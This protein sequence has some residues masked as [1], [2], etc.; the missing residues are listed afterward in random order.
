[1][2]Q[3]LV[4][5]VKRNI[6]DDESLC[7]LYYHWSAYPYDTLFE[8]DTFSK[9]LLKELNCTQE[10]LNKFSD[11]EI[12]LASIRVVESLGGGIEGG[13]NSP[14]FKFIS[15][16][17]PN[18]EFKK[19]GINRTYGLISISEDGRENLHEWMEGHAEIGIDDCL[20]TTDVWY[21]QDSLEEFNKWEEENYK[22][23]DFKI[24][25]FSLSDSISINDA[26]NIADTCKNHLIKTS[27]G[28][29]VEPF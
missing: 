21:G 7:T 4:V 8:I 5:D 10:N 2:G 26:M 22:E 24:V 29:Y 14:E 25:D 17:F 6:G 16:K 1:M 11:E 20:F 18:E 13:E 19:E 27:D 3:R 23:E 12:Q 15:S 9:R 28:I